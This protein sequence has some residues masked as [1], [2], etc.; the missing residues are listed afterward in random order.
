M[1]YSR[2]YFI[3]A[4]L[5]P[6]VSVGGFNAIELVIKNVEFQQNHTNK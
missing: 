3:F 6:V 4:Q 5:A 1:N 2:Q